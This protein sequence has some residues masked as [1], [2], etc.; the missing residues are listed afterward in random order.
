MITN[1][2][3]L[4]FTIA[5]FMSTISMGQSSTGIA[6]FD[7]DFN[8]ALEASRAEKKPVFIDAYTVWCAPCKRMD[9]DVF[10][11]TVVGE[12]YNSDFINVKMDMEKGEGIALAERYGVEAYPTFL[13]VDGEGHL[14]HRAIGFH[15]V[16]D[17]LELADIANDPSRQISAYTRRYDSGEKSPEFLYEYAEALRDVMD[18]RSADITREYLETKDNWDDEQSRGLVMEAIEDAESKYFDFFVEKSPDFIEQFGNKAYEDKLFQAVIVSVLKEDITE[19][20]ASVIFQNA[21]PEKGGALTYK[22]KMAGQYRSGSFEDYAS[23]AWES[24]KQYPYD[25]AMELNVIARNIYR[26]SSDKKSLKKGIKLA[27]A[28]VDIWEQY[29]NLITLSLLY[30]KRGKK[31]KAIKHA[32]K[33]ISLAEKMNF[34]PQEALQIINDLGK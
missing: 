7:G 19:E 29:D 2:S 20:E 27:K 3:F 30:K 5:L 22:L 31:R 9:K 33:A 16:D 8:E 1:Y 18:P 12:R 11:Q 24:H 6:F 10:S 4:G 13:F 21:L 32:Q 25:N 14:I 17:F 34:D 15:K 26:N 23:T 28:S